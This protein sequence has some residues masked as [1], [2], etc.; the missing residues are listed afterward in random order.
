MRVVL[1]PARR[2]L[3]SLWLAGI[4]LR[5]TI[6]AIPP[7]LPV[8]HHS[9]RLSEAA[10][11]ALT[12]LPIFLLA[13]AAVPGSL[14]VSRLGPRR[15][16]MAGLLTVAAAG[17]LRG[18]GASA[19]ILFA[20]TV[21]MGVGI[22]VSQPALPSLVRQWLPS[23][24][25]LATAVYSNGLLIGE[26]ISAALTGAVL[27]WTGSWPSSVAVWSLFPL[28]ALVLVFAGSRHV[29]LPQG[30][31]RVRW[32]PDWTNPLT[33]RL[34]LIL[35]SASISY[36]GINAFVPDYLKVTHHAALITPALTVIN[37][38]QIPP[39]LLIGAFPHL[40][41]A[42]RW[43]IA[44]AGGLTVL[45][46]L[47]MPL[48]G[49]SVVLLGGMLGFASAA[50]FVLALALPPL[51]AAPHDVHRVSAAMFTVSYTCPFIGSLLGGAFWDATGRPIAAFFPVALAGALMVS[52]VAGLRFSRAEDVSEQAHAV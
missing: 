22:S 34:G 26:L 50:I 21:V 46:A 16:L 23:R 42:R 43:P 10:V 40:F 12:A 17:A 13:V 25:G 4:S 11:G 38:G 47:G 51:I 35:G 14:L 15:A 24:V 2:Y 33:W 5:I 18:V 48:G 20:M 39:S 45:G 19:P 28:V 8:I 1:T 36:W 41:I 29:P 3:I 6:L 30:Q 37:F 7:A 31:P 9:L 44:V 52:L 49:V 27:V 32:W